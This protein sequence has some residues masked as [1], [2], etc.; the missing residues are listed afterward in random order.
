M[1]PGFA[2]FGAAAA[3]G[4]IGQYGPAEETVNERNIREYEEEQARERERLQETMNRQALMLRGWTSY[5]DGLQKLAMK[6]H[7][8]EKVRGKD[9]VTAAGQGARDMVASW[10]QAKSTE[11]GLKAME[12]GV[13]A[14]MAFPN[15]PVVAEKLAAAAGYG[16]LATGGGIGAGMITAGGSAGDTGSRYTPES[17]GG[18]GG[19][20][21]AGSSGSTRLVASAT[22]PANYTFAI[23]INHMGATVYGSGGAKQFWQD[24]LLPLAQEAAAS[25]QLSV[26]PMRRN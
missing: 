19:G 9:L 1:R 15:M 4:G 23:T 18:G 17:G 25:G 21:Y 7:Q 6:W 10:L 24:E 20:G 14:L 5:Y 8:G 11:W 13:D 22:A 26:D 3:A 2:G 16:L 12:A